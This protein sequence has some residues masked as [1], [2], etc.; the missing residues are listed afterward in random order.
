M[1]RLWTSFFRFEVRFRNAYFVT[2]AL[3][4]SMANGDPHF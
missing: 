1:S 4:A 2:I 3:V